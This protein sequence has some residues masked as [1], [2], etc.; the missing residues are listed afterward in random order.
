MNIEVYV[1]THKK[2][3]FPKEQVYIPIIAGAKRY[4]ISEFDSSYLR[5]DSGDNISE[6]HDLYSEFTVNYWIW[7][8]SEA[9]VVGINHYRRYFI[10][11]GWLSY[12]YCICTPFRSGI[13]QFVLRRSDIEGIFSHGYDCI[14]PRKNR[15]AHG[16]VKE[17]FERYHNP[18]LLEIISK[19][20][21]DVYPEYLTTYE[22]VMKSCSSWQKCICIM[23]RGLFLEYSEWLFAI[24]GE[25]ENS[26]IDI[27]ERELA[28]VGERLIN[29]FVEKKMSERLI[30][31][32]EMFWINTEYPIYKVGKQR[33]T[34]ITLPYWLINIYMSFDK[35]RR[36]PK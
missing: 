28:M 34:E 18:E 19:I 6:K 35:K 31:V 32:K 15:S 1:I 10:R 7:K 29:V 13:M 20:I 30:R 27:R 16:N 25:I 17:K 14:L 9:D 12:L 33:W 23:T 22:K 4:S 26:G 3:N 8:N 5:D 36:R 21:K 24:L 2:Y 11:G